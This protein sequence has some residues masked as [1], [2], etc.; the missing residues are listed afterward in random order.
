MRCAFTP[1][2]N[3]GVGMWSGLIPD[4]RITA[5]SSYSSG[6]LPYYG[7]LGTNIGHGAWCAAAN[8]SNQFLEIDLGI[9]HSISGITI[10]GKHRLS[11]DNFKE[12]WVTE[13][14]ISFTT[15]RKKWNYVTDVKTHQPIVS[16][17]DMRILSL[18]QKRST[19]F[20]SKERPIGF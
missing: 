4:E 12:A 10:E 6:H 17:K 1:V 3:Y 20:I 14:L 13:F 19:R 5:S 18:R 7:R 15:S 11:S 2:K 9:E 8:N 16:S